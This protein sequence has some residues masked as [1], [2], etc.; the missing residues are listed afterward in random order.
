MP[1]HPFGA[2]PLLT[3]FQLC[4]SW[5]TLNTQASWCS[6]LPWSAT[7]TPSCPSCSEG[8]STLTGS[9]GFPPLRPC[10]QSLSTRLSALHR[11]QGSGRSCV[12]PCSA[13]PAVPGPD[14][15]QLLP[16]CRSAVG[17]CIR[18]PAL[19]NADAADL[20]LAGRLCGKERGPGLESGCLCTSG[21][22][23]QPCGRHWQALLILW[24]LSLGRAFGGPQ[25]PLL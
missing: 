1:L 5:L 4:W 11:V 13:P 7:S 12:I 10:P 22:S 3:A 15:Q 24:L 20:S 25:S 16:I 6:C 8:P 19:Y 18:P 2:A 23:W 21:T 17:R 9:P 14:T